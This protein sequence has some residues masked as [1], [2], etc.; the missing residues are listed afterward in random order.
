MGARQRRKYQTIYARPLGQ[1]IRV[2][3]PKF[4]SVQAVNRYLVSGPCHRLDK[5]RTHVLF[6]HAHTGRGCRGGRVCEHGR[7]AVFCAIPGVRTSVGRRGCARKYSKGP[8]PVKKKS[9]VFRTKALA[10]ADIRTMPEFIAQ[11][12]K[13]A[14]VARN[15]QDGNRLIG[16]LH[17]RTVTVDCADISAFNFSISELDQKKLMLCGLEAVDSFAQQRTIVPCCRSRS[18]GTQTSPNLRSDP[19]TLGIPALI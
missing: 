4:R 9:L 6:R 16:E 14:M 19:T 8:R 12:V 15:N 11:I 2:S 18:V 17:N 3:S 13:S 7:P 10:A 5:L 1:I